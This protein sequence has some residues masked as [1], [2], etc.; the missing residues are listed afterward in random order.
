MKKLLSK[1]F[2]AI[3]LCGFLMGNTICL[4]ATSLQGEE[5][6]GQKAPGFKLPSHLGGDIN[7]EQYLGKK[8]V[9]LAFYPKNFT[10]GWEFE[11][12]SFQAAL[13]RYEEANVQVL[14]ISKDTLDS[15]KDFAK[16][17]GATYPLLSDTEGKMAASFGAFK[18]GGSFFARRT[19]IV[20]KE[21]KI[22]YAQNGMPNHD[23]LLK[24]I[25]EFK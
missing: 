1:I 4:Q 5:A 12:K 16:H 14:A 21:G 9:V 10:G 8:V 11:L 2:L 19:I 13:K 22:R 24:L 20:D 18:E 17:C 7:L 15:H 6:V 3:A 23:N 25:S